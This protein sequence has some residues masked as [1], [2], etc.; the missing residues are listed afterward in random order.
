M[1]SPLILLS[2]L[3]LVDYAYKV[4]FDTKTYMV[5]PNGTPSKIY[6]KYVA[7]YSKTNF[8]LTF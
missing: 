2:M 1:V 6:S 5:V 4:L 8:R 3:N 7:G